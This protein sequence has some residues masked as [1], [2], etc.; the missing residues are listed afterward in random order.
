[1]ISLLDLYNWLLENIL[2][3]EIGLLIV[4]LILWYL[5][6]S[7][8][9]LFEQAKD[10]FLKNPE[11]I[12]LL[13]IGV[14]IFSAFISETQKFWVFSNVKGGKW[15]GAST[16][17]LILALGAAGA[18]YGL[19][20]S[21]RRLEKF[22]HQVETSDRNLFND[23]LSRAIEA[24]GTKDNLAVR[25]AG[26]RL[27]DSLIKDT[28]ADHDNRDVLLKIL[29]GY[30]RDRAV[31]P[32]RD[33]D[34]ILPDAP[35]RETRTDIE[36]AIKILFDR[37]PLDERGE[38]LLGNLD[39][40]GLQLFEF[41]LRRAN[42][43][44]ANLEG[45]NLSNA[46]LQGAYLVNTNL[47]GA[48]LD[49]ANLQG[50]H[51]FDA[52]LQGANLYHANLQGADTHMSDITIADL[53]DAHSFTQ[54]QLDVCIYENQKPPLGLLQ[55][56]ELPAERAYEWAKNENG[57]MCRRFVHNKEWIDEGTPWWYG[58]EGEEEGDSQE[59]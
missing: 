12:L 24:I 34:G 31:M 11:F 43:E 23:R 42:L 8:L 52:K 1:M 39:L 9:A 16:R 55:G 38:Y 20:L 44:R 13:L 37:L 59:P 30:I 53:E 25:N 41:D 29:H 54:E 46:K 2:W 48:N 26:L 35:S 4:E 17:S 49:D 40:R 19:I 45:A 6:T 36:L 28:L 56:L 32:S 14:I 50:A 3:M 57:H 33:K 5:E 21:A 58:G 10:F 7:L 15:D 18:I 47:Q 27:I 51:L 22:S